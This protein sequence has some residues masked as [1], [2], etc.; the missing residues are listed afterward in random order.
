MRSKMGLSFCL[1]I[2]TVVTFPQLPKRVSGLWTSMISQGQVSSC[3][4]LR[5]IAVDLFLVLLLSLD[6]NS[7]QYR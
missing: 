7:L 6:R 2:S 4:G 5:V 1:K 3:R